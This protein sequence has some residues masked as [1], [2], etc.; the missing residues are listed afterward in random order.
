[1]K[2]LILVM[3]LAI[4]SCWAADKP[5]PVYER[6][7]ITAFSN[8]GRQMD[9]WFI[10]Q[11]E[12]CNYTVQNWRLFGGITIGGSNDVRMRTVTFLY[13]WEK[14]GESANPKSRTTGGCRPK[15]RSRT[16]RR[17][18]KAFPED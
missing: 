9:H 6:G 14:S 16:P 18:A 10:V 17:Q 1:M 12:C 4:R 7:V 11:T 2:T 5:E 15:V 13:G 3:V 8:A